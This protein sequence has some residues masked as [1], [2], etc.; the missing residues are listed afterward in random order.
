M[1]T[2]INTARLDDL[3]QRWLEKVNTL[4][5][6]V[7]ICRDESAKPATAE[8]LIPHALKLQAEVEAIH[9]QVMHLLRIAPEEV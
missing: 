7:M 3:K 4:A 9:R 2:P 1:P 8:A 5:T 6:L